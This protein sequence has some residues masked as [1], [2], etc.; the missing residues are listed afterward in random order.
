VTLLSTLRRRAVHQDGVEKRLG[1]SGQVGVRLRFQ[2]RPFPDHC[3]SQDERD[4]AVGRSVHKGLPRGERL[5]PGCG[6]Q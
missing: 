3:T 2:A 6:I 1:G 5:L 4:A